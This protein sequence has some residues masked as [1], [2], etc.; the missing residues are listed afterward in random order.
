MKTLLFA[1]AALVLPAF[2]TAQVDRATLTGV[3]RDPSNAAIA[4]AVVT[5]THISTGVATR[6]VTGV[7]GTYL[8]VNLPPGEAI[9]DAEAP[10]FQRF[11][12]TVL[13]EIGNRAS[14]D[15]TLPV[16]AVTET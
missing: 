15:L 16:G 9:L 8:V 10:G 11:T 6:A 13:L 5:V 2:A 3:V 14:L 12:R 7:E 4:G 1:L